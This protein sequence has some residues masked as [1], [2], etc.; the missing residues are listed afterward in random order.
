MLPEA[1]SALA[2]A[3]ATALVGAVATDAWDVTK[4]R[5]ARM[6]GRGDKSRE[7]AVAE[8]LEVTRAQVTEAGPQAQQVR[9]RQEAEWTVRL[10]TVLAEHPHLADELSALVAEIGPGGGSRSEGSVVQHANAYD[11]AQ[12]SVVGHG[13]MNVT[14]GPSGQA[15]PKAR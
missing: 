4:N 7:L 13:T 9:L 5:F 1:L 6:L 10:E 12:Q 3:G 15:H 11:N 2:G 8:R 14:F